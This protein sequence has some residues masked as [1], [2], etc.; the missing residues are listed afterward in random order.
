MIAIT[1]GTQGFDDATVER[2]DELAAQQ[3]QTRSLRFNRQVHG[4]A[5]WQHSA[6]YLTTVR[7]F[8]QAGWAGLRR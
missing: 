2:E 6:N 7:I 4:R 3:T 8:C 1:F 5:L